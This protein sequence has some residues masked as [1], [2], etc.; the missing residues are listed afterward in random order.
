MK[1]YTIQFSDEPS[2]V[3][4]HQFLDGL[5]AALKAEG[6][7]D[8]RVHGAGTQRGTLTLSHHD[9]SEWVEEKLDEEDWVLSYR[10]DLAA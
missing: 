3:E 6:D 10:D 8:F 1:N 4:I 9:A 2:E 7:A 5:C